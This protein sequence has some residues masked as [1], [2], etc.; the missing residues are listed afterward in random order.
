MSQISDL[1]PVF[2]EFVEAAIDLMNE[3]TIQ[4]EEDPDG[5]TNSIVILNEKLKNKLHEMDTTVEEGGSLQ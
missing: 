2:V 5:V 3:I 1:R 4:T